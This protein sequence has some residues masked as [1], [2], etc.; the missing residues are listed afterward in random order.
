M[1]YCFGKNKGYLSLRVF[2]FEGFVLVKIL[3]KCINL[4]FIGIFLI[5]FFVLDLDWYF[6]SNR[7]KK[8]IEIRYFIKFK[9]FIN[10][11]IFFFK[12]CFF[13]FCD[14]KVLLILFKLF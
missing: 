1:W 7:N 10:N 4:R 3:L 8:N 11:G 2:K 5:F 12:F 9:F 13:Y 14:V 6:K